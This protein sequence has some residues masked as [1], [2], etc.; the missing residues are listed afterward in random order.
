M[1]PD[2][3]VRIGRTATLA[4]SLGLAIFPLSAFGILYVPSALVVRGDAAATARNIMSSEWL[5]RGAIISHLVCEIVLACLALLL[6]QLLKPVNKRY[7][8]LMVVLVLLGIPI[9]VVNEVNH[10]AVLRLLSGADYLEPLTPIQLH[11]Q[12]M[13]FLDLYDSGIIVAQVFWALWLLPQGYLIFRS[14]FLPGWLGILLI[15]GGG[16]YLVDVVLMVLFP[17]VN[18][19]IGVFTFIGEL[20]LPLWLLFKGVNVD[21]WQRV[22]LA[23]GAVKGGVEWPGHRH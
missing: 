13:L 1:A 21:Q 22:A 5:F 23:E 9:A 12:V 4:G 8:V 20:L 3:R 7:A 18:V 16:G 15:I 17:N 10:F 2:D 6:Y 14:G 19:R 11:A